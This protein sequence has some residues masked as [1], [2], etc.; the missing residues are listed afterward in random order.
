M[1]SYLVAIEDKLHLQMVMW[2][3]HDHF[4][5][6][7][8]IDIKHNRWDDMKIIRTWFVRIL[9][10]HKPS[11][12][13]FIIIIH[14]F[15]PAL[16]DRDKHKGGNEEISSSKGGCLHPWQSVLELNLI[17]Y[18]CEECK[19]FYFENSPLMQQKL[20]FCNY[21]KCTLLV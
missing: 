7:I 3:H 11:R 10:F 4:I 14:R 6:P 9:I 12:F 21:G 1:R 19:S 8:L 5:L 18:R 17:K 2:I 13:Y 15:I 20:S 16:E